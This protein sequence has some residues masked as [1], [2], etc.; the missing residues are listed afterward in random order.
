LLRRFVA[1][2]GGEVHRPAVPPRLASFPP[3]EWVAAGANSWPTRDGLGLAIVLEIRMKS[4][5]KRDFVEL[6]Q[7]VQALGNGGWNAG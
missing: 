7:M 3:A 2:S 1:S 4:T 5:A 6:D